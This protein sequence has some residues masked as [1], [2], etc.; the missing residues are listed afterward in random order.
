MLD[1]S[2]AEASRVSGELQEM[3][4]YL[5]AEGDQ[6]SSL[7]LKTLQVLRPYELMSTAECLAQAALLLEGRHCQYKTLQAPM[8]G[9]VNARTINVFANVGGPR[10]CCLWQGMLHHT[11]LKDAGKLEGMYQ[12]A[13][14]R[15]CNQVRLFT[16][17]AQISDAGAYVR[18][19]WLQ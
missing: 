1:N 8:H 17:G 10:M 13:L 5:E 18:N 3:R 6:E 7:F 11:L 14:N 2:E 12:Q 4:M 19:M 9:Q 16:E 15:I